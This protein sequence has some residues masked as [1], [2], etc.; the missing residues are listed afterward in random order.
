MASPH[1]GRCLDHH[2]QPLL[3][4]HLAIA[5]TDEKCDYPVER[6]AEATAIAPAERE[7][8]R[9]ERI[10]HHDDAARTPDFLE[11]PRPRLGQTHQHMRRAQRAA[12]ACAS[13]PA[14]VAVEVGEVTGM[15]L[16]NNAPTQQ[17]S[18]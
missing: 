3:F 10:G 13:Y 7:L 9:I 2:R 11:Q 17:A 6:D 1:F 14:S 15:D 4:I 8:L 5:G 16:Q 18:D 12:N